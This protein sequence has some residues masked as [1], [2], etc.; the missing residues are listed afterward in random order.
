M[1]V[2]IVSDWNCHSGIYTYTSYLYNELKDKIEVEII[3]IYHPHTFDIFYFSVSN[4]SL[5]TIL[6]F[7]SVIKRIISEKKKLDIVHF[8]EP[9]SCT[10]SPILYILL[11]LGRRPKIVTTI[12]EPLSV[13]GCKPLIIRAYRRLLNWI[14]VHFTDLIVVH[15]EEAE[16][17]MRMIGAED[18][19]IVPHGCC[20]PQV[21]SKDRCKRVLG[22][23]D[24]KVITLFGFIDD[25]KDYG[26]VKRLL[27]HMSEDTVFLIAGGMPHPAS[28]AQKSCYYM[29]REMEKKDGRV[30]IMGF[31]EEEDIPIVFNATDIMLFPYKWTV[32]SGVLN[33][34]LA[35]GVPS[36][37]S[38]LPYF[39]YIKKRY[40]CVEVARDDAELLSKILLLLEDDGER[41]KLIKNAKKY[42]EETNWSVIA[43]RHIELYRRVLDE[44]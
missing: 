21:L 12:H 3:P 19:V 39:R 32:Q 34:A 30:R 1:R 10:F 44:K 35:Y 4:F 22:L 43:K 7:L 16:N 23:E 29:L 36:I 20:H 17:L 24:K 18:V 31:I 38:D 25:R 14:I 26:V 2:G 27:P 37:S 9:G 41:E 13:G 6:A 11:A 8:Q 5:K 15:T 40:E 42:W 33:I 28:K